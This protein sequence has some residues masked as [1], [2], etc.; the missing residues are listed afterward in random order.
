M[1]KSYDLTNEKLLRY[2]TSF[3]FAYLLLPPNCITGDIFFHLSNENILSTIKQKMKIE[4]MR[5]MKN[6]SLMNE[7]LEPTLSR[8]MKDLIQI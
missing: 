3:L 4:I 2:S 1:R 8:A 5:R 7:F 6:K